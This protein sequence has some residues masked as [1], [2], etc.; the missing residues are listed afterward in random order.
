MLGIHGKLSLQKISMFY[1][2][3]LKL[4]NDDFCFYR[5]P[6]EANIIK[7]E[8]KQTWSHKSHQRKFLSTTHFLVSA[9]LFVL[10]RLSPYFRITIKL[11][12]VLM[13]HSSIYRYRQT[14]S[15]PCYLLFIY[16]LQWRVFIF[17]CTWSSGFQMV[18]SYEYFPILGCISWVRL[19]AFICHFEDFFRNQEI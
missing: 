8:Y 1:K 6:V 2:S 9:P 3:W 18:R 19:T 17:F 15:F 13:M 7:W 14:A 4:W 16:T 12:P 11:S 5:F 10:L